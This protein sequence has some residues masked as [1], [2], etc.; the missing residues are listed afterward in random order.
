MCRIPGVYLGRGYGR[1]IIT[2]ALLAALRGYF[3]CDQPKSI[4]IF[5]RQALGAA[6]SLLSL[7]TKVSWGSFET[8][9]GRYFTHN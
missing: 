4:S 2:S 6:F 8:S 7:V 1:L 9:S 3:V 5:S